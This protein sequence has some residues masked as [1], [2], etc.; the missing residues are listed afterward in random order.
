MPPA[1][2]KRERDICWKARDGYFGCLSTN[3]TPH[4]RINHEKKI[5]DVPPE[6]DHKA[7]IEK[8]SALKET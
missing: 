4:F 3:V 7:L 5:L 6:I 8:C 2:R 1:L